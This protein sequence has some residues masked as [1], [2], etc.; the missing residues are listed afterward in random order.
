MA[1]FL[2]ILA[3][4]IMWKGAKE[5]VRYGAA[6]LLAEYV[7]LLLYFTVFMWRRTKEYEYVLVPFWS[8][9]AMLADTRV[10]MQEVAMNFAALPKPGQWSVPKRSLSTV[11]AR[12]SR[13]RDSRRT[14]YSG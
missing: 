14:P 2:L 7:A 5:G 4:A 3:A 6:F 8:Y 10:L 12:R 9:R 11:S 13:G 1:A